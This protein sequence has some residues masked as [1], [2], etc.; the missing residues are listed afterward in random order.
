MT[1]PNKTLCTVRTFSFKNKACN[2]ICKLLKTIYEHYIDKQGWKG[3][4]NI[5]SGVKYQFFVCLAICN[6]Y[7]K[8]Y[9]F[10]Y[11]ALFPKVHIKGYLISFQN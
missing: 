1:T 8:L 7:Y 2:P 5:V 3:V 10:L 4:L 6:V 11:I 9:G